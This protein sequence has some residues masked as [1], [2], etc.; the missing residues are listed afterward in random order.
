VPARQAQG[1]RVGV[2]EGGALKVELSGDAVWISG[3][4]P[5]LRDLARWCLALS[6]ATPGSHVHFDGDLTLDDGSE[7]LIVQRVEVE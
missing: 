1:V 2:A 5:G 6:G 3:D 7:D 4:G